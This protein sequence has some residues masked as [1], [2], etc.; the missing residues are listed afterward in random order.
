MSI[1]SRVMSD[2]NGRILSEILLHSV[3]KIQ[4][5]IQSNKYIR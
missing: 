5:Y 2:N 3:E 4:V 1:V